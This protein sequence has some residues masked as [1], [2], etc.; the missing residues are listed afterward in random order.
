[1]RQTTITKPFD[2]L[3]FC[4]PEDLPELLESATALPVF[5]SALRSRF[6][7]EAGTVSK[8]KVASHVINEIVRQTPSH[9]TIHLSPFDLDERQIQNI[10]FDPALELNFHTLSLSGNKHI[11]EVLLDK[12]LR[13]Y[14]KINILHLLDTSLISLMAKLDWLKKHGIYHLY[15]SDFIA[16]PF[17]RMCEIELST[18]GLS[19]EETEKIDKDP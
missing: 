19:E 18:P 16:L 15:D 6:Y 7:T 17:K 8:S 13:T 4:S 10:L 2:E 11:Q 5:Y 3:L 14:P 12:I 1:L 9:G